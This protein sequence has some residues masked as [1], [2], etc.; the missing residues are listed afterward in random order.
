MAKER[1]KK[2]LFKRWW[3]WVIV[4]IVIGSIATNGEETEK[5][6]AETEEATEATQETATTPKEEKPAEPKEEAP[7]AEAKE[8]VLTEEKFAK[9]EN[10]MTYDEVKAIIGAEGSVMSE[11]GDKGTEFHTVIYE[12]E[13]DGIFSNANFMFQGEKLTSKSQIGVSETSDVTVT[14][15]E[16]DKISNGMTYEEVTAIIGGEGNMLSET[17][18]KGTDFYTVM[19]DYKGEGD[20]G[21]NANFMFQDGKLQNKS[22]FGLK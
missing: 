18:E 6:V 1:K 20:L 15:A 8:G 16:F 4:V 10:G 11:S 21:A 9:I 14:K 2:P 5:E 3:F 12:W 17:G 19:Y 7:K 22:Q 13:T